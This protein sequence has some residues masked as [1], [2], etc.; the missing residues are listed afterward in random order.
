MTL[1]HIYIDVTFLLILKNLFR[2]FAATEQLPFT[3]NTFS[4][5]DHTNTFINNLSRS[6]VHHSGNN[7]HVLSTHSH[8]TLLSTKRMAKYYSTFVCNSSDS[9]ENKRTDYGQ[10][11]LCG[12]KFSSISIIDIV[13]SKSLIFVNDHRV[14]AS[15]SFEN[16]ITNYDK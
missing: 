5:K 4:H 11:L 16:S 14:A 6:T 9:M 2:E 10:I 13:W 7:F 1:A 15:T 3:R 8:L 12:Q